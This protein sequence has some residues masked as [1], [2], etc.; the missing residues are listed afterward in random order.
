[1]GMYQ[2][3][4]IYQSEQLLIDFHIPILGLLS[5]QPQHQLLYPETTSSAR[6]TVA[7]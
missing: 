6:T 5:E 1:M 4:S 3:Y 7:F 2:F